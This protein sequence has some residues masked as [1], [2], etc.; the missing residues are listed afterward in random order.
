MKKA[1]DC[2]NFMQIDTWV[3]TNL[4]TFP[5]YDEEN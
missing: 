2:I 5:I 3:P 4:V 1:I